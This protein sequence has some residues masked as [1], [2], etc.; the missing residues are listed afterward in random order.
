M[1]TALHGLVLYLTNMTGMI[2]GF[3]AFKLIGGDQLITQVT[4]S[5]V[6]SIILFMLYFH[7]LRKISPKTHPYTAARFVWI[8][9][10][11][12][13]W[14]PVIFIPLHYL[15]QGYLTGPGNIV[16]VMLFQVPINAI[17]LGVVYGVF[18]HPAKCH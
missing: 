2:A 11:A 15:T 7:V 17:A 18:A 12:I 4:T 1:K 9:I 10:A 8:L 14:H 16:A 13:C 6:I 3:I 5:A